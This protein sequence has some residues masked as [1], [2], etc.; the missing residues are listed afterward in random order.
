MS[1]PQ[2]AAGGCFQ[3]LQHTPFP[4]PRSWAFS[5]ATHHEDDMLSC[6]GDAPDDTA[7]AC[8]SPSVVGFALEMSLGSALSGP[9]LPWKSIP[10]LTGRADG[11]SLLFFFPHEVKR[12][13]LRTRTTQ[14][15]TSARFRK[16]TSSPTSLLVLLGMDFASSVLSPFFPVGCVPQRQQRAGSVR[17]ETRACFIYFSHDCGIGLGLGLGLGSCGIE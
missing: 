17:H 12:K 7:R 16:A 4:H 1:Q 3:I 13:G 15:G 10:A 2:C 6:C 8:C 11:E 14:N 5:P 9:R